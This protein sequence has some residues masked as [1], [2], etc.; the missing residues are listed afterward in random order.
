ML[1]YYLNGE[2]DREVIAIE[3][4]V[5]VVIA[6]AAVLI[7]VVSGVNVVALML[8]T[9]I[10]NLSFQCKDILPNEKVFVYVNASSFTMYVACTIKSQQHCI[11]SIEY[12]WCLKQ[13]GCIDL[14]DCS[15]QL[16]ID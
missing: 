13:P 4:V 11:T 6:A 5:I 9:H 16:D 2:S 8:E 14:V 10:Y 1:T 15:S 12:G 7:V 3:G